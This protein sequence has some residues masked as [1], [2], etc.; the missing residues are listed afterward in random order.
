MNLSKPRSKTLAVALLLALSL[1]LSNLIGLTEDQYPIQIKNSNTQHFAEASRI[2]QQKCIDCHSP[3]MTRFPFYSSLPIAKQL[4]EDDIKNASG[5]LE[6]S[7]DFYSGEKSFTPLMLARI[8]G[9]LRNNAMPPNLYLSMH[10]NG[11]LSE[12]EKGLLLA[13]IDEERELL[14]WSKDS[15]PTLKGEPVHPLPLSVALNPR[16]VALGQRL[17]FEQRLSGDGSMSCASCHSLTKGGTDQAKVATGIRGQKGPINS[18][19]VFNASYNMAQFWDGRA[20]DLTEQAAGPVA[21]PGE[22]GATWETV[23]KTLNEDERYKA[24]FAE[25][26]PAEGISLKTITQ[27]IATFEESLVTGGSRFDRYL[28]GEKDVLTPEEKN[29]YHLFKMNCA[30]CHLGPTLGGMSYEKMGRR[31]D[32]F[33]MRGGSLT[34]ADNG[35][36]NVTHDEKDKHF[37]KV[38]NLRNIALTHPYFHDG[39]AQTLEDAVRIMAI[40][41]TGKELNK[42]EIS[43]VVAFLKTLTGDYK[44]VPL[45]KLKD[46]DITSPNF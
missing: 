7:K 27:S 19:T 21:N 32:Y 29:G 35:R 26:Y 38:P 8:E 24:M 6:I 46:S 2:I 25:L 40:V 20:K 33:K 45:D 5:R 18:P 22:M 16:K 3:G 9:A 12:K 10:W 31:E 17:F 13:W 39:S 37:F 34:E 15:A 14:E 4:M 28:R 42:K 36:Y 43:D 11:G 30:S 44:N 23:V 41:Q 1:P